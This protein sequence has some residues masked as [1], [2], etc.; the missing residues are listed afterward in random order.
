MSPGFGRSAASAVAFA[1]LQGALPEYLIDLVGIAGTLVLV[2]MVVAIG[3]MVYRHLTGGIEWPDDKKEDDDE[4]SRG[5]QDDEW[6][7]Y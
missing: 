7:Y 3:A 2:L 5:S 6:D 4:V 1:P